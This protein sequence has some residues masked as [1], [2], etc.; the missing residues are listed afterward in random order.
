MQQCKCNA[1]KKGLVQTQLTAALGRVVGYGASLGI[2]FDKI[3]L[4]D[5]FRRIAVRAAMRPIFDAELKA[6]CMVE[7]PTIND[8]EVE[9]GPNCA[10]NKVDT[11]E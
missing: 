10:A 9:S 6:G 11:P 4:R 3:G 1:E 7:M 8:D 5:S 2:K